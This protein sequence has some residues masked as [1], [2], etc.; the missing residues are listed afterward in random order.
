MTNLTGHELRALH[1]FA[2]A[3]VLAAKARGLDV[4]ELAGI[5]DKLVTMIAERAGVAE[6][7]ELVFRL[8]IQHDVAP[9]LNRYAQLEPW[10]K[11]KLTET[12]DWTIRAAMAHW[13]RAKLDK[14]RRRIV[15]FVRFSS[16][17]IDE[18][19]IDI[20]GGKMPLDRL[21][22]AGI[23]AGDAKKHIERVPEWQPAEPLK[24]KCLIEVFEEAAR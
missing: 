6:R 1:A 4:E 10:R 12:L 5:R 13:P 20:L 15:R 14:P 9:T 3:Y 18:V 2:D 19:A 16:R 7:G 22:H 17:R 24:G 8:E 11:K 23:L 21:V